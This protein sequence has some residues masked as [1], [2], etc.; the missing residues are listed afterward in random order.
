VCALR[1][2]A[3]GKHTKLF[4]TTTTLCE[5]NRHSTHRDVHPERLTPDELWSAVNRW[6]SATRYRNA[7]FCDAILISN[8]SFYQDRLGTSIGKALKKEW[9]F[10]RSILPEVNI[11]APC[12]SGWCGVTSCNDGTAQGLN[13]QTLGEWFV[14]KLAED[15]AT[16]SAAAGGGGRPLVQCLLQRICYGCLLRRVAPPNDDSFRNLDSC[17]DYTHC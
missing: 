7:T 15:Y 10:L 16:R 3:F 6:A 9:R 1:S 17:G 4:L 11:A 2:H 8:A 5:R 13:N 14:R 12:L